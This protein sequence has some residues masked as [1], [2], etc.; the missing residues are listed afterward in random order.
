M[1]PVRR[2]D[3]RAHPLLRRLLYRRGGARASARPSSWPRASTPAPTGCSWPAGTVVF[4]IDQPEV[5][6]FKTTTLAGLGA[7]PTA[8]RRTVAVDLRNDW[9]AAL[10]EAGFDPAEADRLDR[11]GTVRLPAARSPGPPARPDH[12]AERAGQ[13]TGRRGCAQPR[14]HRRRRGPREDA[15]RLRHSGASTASTSISPSWC[16]SATAPRSPP[17]CTATAGRPPRSTTNDLLI[18]Y[19]LAPIDEDPRRQRTSPA[20]STSAQKGKAAMAR[21]DIRQLGSGVQR[22]RDG[23]HGRR[24]PRAGHRRTRR[25]DRRPVRGAAGARGRASTSSPRSSTAR[26]PS[27]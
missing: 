13:P 24:R 9:P 17:I 11:R 1:Q 18:K 25:H 19:G 15:G 7:E 16:T 4:E 26:R 20:S 5:I 10:S 14:R 12:R 21:T 27:D 8:D 6:E 3:G 2:R 22:R 23:D